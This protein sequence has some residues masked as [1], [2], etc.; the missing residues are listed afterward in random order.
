MERL[1]ELFAGYPDLE[2]LQL[3]IGVVF[4]HAT[5]NDDGD[6]TGK[7]ITRNGRECAWKAVVTKPEQRLTGSPDLLVVLNGDRWEEWSEA[8][9]TSVLDE[10]LYAVEVVEDPETKGPA[11]DDAGRPRIR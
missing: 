10:V 9:Q 7:A 4:A 3:K 5:T 6:P 8:R 2:R 11:S 1:A